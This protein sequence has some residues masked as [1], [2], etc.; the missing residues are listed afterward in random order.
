MKKLKRELEEENKE[1]YAEI[2]HINMLFVK[3]KKRLNLYK[4]VELEIER[5]EKE[6]HRLKENYREVCEELFTIE[7]RIAVLNSQ[8]FNW[9]K[10]KEILTFKGED[11]ET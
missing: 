11:D 10:L 7:K 2:E 8:W 5:L 6:N 9:G 1:L 4:D 3:A